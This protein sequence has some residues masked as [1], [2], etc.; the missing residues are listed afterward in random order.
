VVALGDEREA[1][2]LQA[3]DEQQFPERLRAVQAVGEDPPGEVLQLLLAARRG[4]AG[5]AQVVAQV[6]VR[7]VDPD[8]P[9][10]VE[11]DA[12]E[13]LAKAGDE[14]QARLDQ[15]AQLVVGRR[16]P[17]ED[18]DRCDVQ[19]CPGLLEVQERRVECRDAVTVGDASIVPRLATN[20]DPVLSALC[21]AW[22]RSPIWTS[23]RSMR[24]SSCCAARSCA[25][26][27]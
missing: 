3:V 16:G 7:V 15:L 27:R 21:V 18:G 8:R 2:A 10:L 13:A 11:R 23:T 14:V 4:Q 25:G 20:T 17:V 22:L 5:V 6:E 1:A 12:G 9:A 19:A 26:C 24:A